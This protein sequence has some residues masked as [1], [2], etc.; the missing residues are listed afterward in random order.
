MNH[1][2][3]LGVSKTATL[4]D[5]K[6]AYKKLAKENHP[7]RGGNTSKFAEINAAYD[8][9]KDSAKRQEY[10]NSF[11]HRYTTQNNFNNRTHEFDFNFFNDFFE[12]SFKDY[13]VHRNKDI[14]VSITLDL[15]DVF[16]KK[17]IQISYTTSTGSTESVNVIVPAGIKTGDV[18]KYANL[19]DNADPRFPRGN[20]N[21]KINVLDTTEWKR[22]NNDLWHKQQVNV[23]DL[24]LGCVIII[25]TPENK[26][27]KLN[28]PKG[29]KPTSVFSIPGHGIP[30]RTTG[31]RGNVYVQLDT[32]V[33]NIN[34]L[35]IIDKLNEIKQTINN[36]EIN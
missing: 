23:F 13:A 21:I 26:S 12:R 25:T 32:L 28:I 22:T 11:Q 20:L 36:K 19:G 9:L 30:D 3:T 10:D 5:I 4:E 1:Y 16:Y 15:E 34:D 14:N 29:S 18:I 33:P 2:E 31:T 27:V 35:S 17:D 6:Q 7:D 8:V 24:L